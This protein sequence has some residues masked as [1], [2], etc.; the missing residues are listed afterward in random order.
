[1]IRN[2]IRK[3]YMSKDDVYVELLSIKNYLDTKTNFYFYETDFDELSLMAAVDKLTT[4][5]LEKEYNLAIEKYLFTGNSSERIL[6]YFLGE[7]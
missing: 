6:D 4:A 2:T 3:D 7:K 5:D 1:M